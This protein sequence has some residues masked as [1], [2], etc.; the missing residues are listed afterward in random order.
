MVAA[1]RSFFEIFCVDRDETL[2]RH[3]YELGDRQWDIPDLRRLL[4]E[5]IPKSAA[6]EGYEVEHDFRRLRLRWEERGGPQV[7]PP[8]AQ[9]FG[10]R[11]VEAAAAH[12]L[13]GRVELTFAPAG[14]RAEIA[15]PL[16]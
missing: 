2:G 12:E 11:L 14:L 3:L 8:A 7:R 9:G 16:G 15:F 5:V 6:V 1:S 13:H 4:E 10:T